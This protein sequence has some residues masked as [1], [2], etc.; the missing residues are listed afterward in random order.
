MDT[1]LELQVPGLAARPSLAVAP[2]LRLVP[3]QEPEPARGPRA[4]LESFGRRHVRPLA[5]RT[6]LVRR[7]WYWARARFGAGRR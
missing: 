1:W 3:P 4:A 7:C 5:D 6:A 2:G